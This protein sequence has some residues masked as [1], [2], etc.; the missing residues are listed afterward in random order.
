MQAA[1][2]AVVDF[3][4]CRWSRKKLPQHQSERGL[5]MSLIKATGQVHDQGK[6]VER[7]GLPSQRD[8]YQELD[9]VLYW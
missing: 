9:S 3:R 1:A 5:S 2:Q 6:T 8:N 4:M 7:P